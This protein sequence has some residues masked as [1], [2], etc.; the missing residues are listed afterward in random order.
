[1]Q[2]KHPAASGD[3]GALPASERDSALSVSESDVRQAV[4]SFLAGSSGGPDGLR[5]QHLKNLVLYRESGSDFLAALTLF[6][7]SVLAG[8]CPQNIAPYFFG[9][10]L[11]ALSKNSG[12]IRPI[13]V[14]LTLRRLACK[15]ASS[16]GSKRLVSSF[17]PRQLGV[18][19]AGGCEVAI[20]SA[21][22]FMENM[23]SDYM[24]VKLDFSNAFNSLHRCEML[25]SIRDS[26]PVVSCLLFG[27]FTAVY[28]ILW[29]TYH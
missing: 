28:S 27:V 16:F 3:T 20:H 10:R 11:L 7:N 13:A 21:R 25:T 8:S 15:C 24:V 2:D 18:G 19:V 6:V 23:P 29:I 9:G 5:P 1:V 22:C 26:V 14:G 12:G 4:L 17:H